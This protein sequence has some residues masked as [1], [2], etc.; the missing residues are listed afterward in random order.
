MSPGGSIPPS[1]TKTSRPAEHKVMGT[2]SKK[3]ASGSLRVLVSEALL[4][5]TPWFLDLG[6]LAIGEHKCHMLDSDSEHSQLSGEPWPR[7][8]RYCNL[9]GPIS[10]S[11]KGQ[12]IVLSSQLL[13]D[14]GNMVRPMN[15]I[16]HTCTAGRYVP[17]SEVTLC[18]TPR[19][20]IG[21]SARLQMVVLAETLHTGQ[22]NLY[23]KVVSISTRT[24]H[25][26]FHHGSSQCHKPAI[27]YLADRPRECCHIE[28][29]VLVLLWAEWAPSVG[30][31]PVCLGE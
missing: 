2:G 27:R 20:W 3:F 23:P 25:L 1:E 7:P 6:M 10:E 14:G 11:L 15:P 13:Y 21:H 22:A 31:G 9:A 18:R 30:H 4:I 12:S 24:K 19:W 29:S 28:G 5:S 26:L 17:R 8:E 16:N